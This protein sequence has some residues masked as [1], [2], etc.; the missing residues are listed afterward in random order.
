MIPTDIHALLIEDNAEHALLLG[1]LLATSAN[2]RFR[3][4]VA[5]TLAEGL[6]KIPRDKFDIILL[7]LTLPDCQGLPTF[8]KVS[9]AAG[10][11]PIVVLSGIGD[12]ALAIETVQKGAQDYLVKGHVD[13]HLL[14]RSVQYAVERKRTQLELERA[15][16]ELEKRVKERTIE[17]LAT[18]EHLQREV[19]DRK[20][21]ES[22]AL[23]S[24]RQLSAALT[25]LR[26]MQQDLVRR[27]RFQALAQMA[28]GIAHEFNNIL[29]PIAG[30]AE[31]LLKHPALADVPEAVRNALQKVRN[32]AF[33]GSKAV[34]RVR[35]FARASAGEFGPVS[36]EELVESAIGLTEPRWRDE[37]Q[38]AGVTIVLA[39]EVHDAP[40]LHGDAAQLREVLTHLIFNAVQAIARRGLIKVGAEK[41]GGGVALYVQDDGRG[42]SEA[43][44]KR[45]LDPR[46]ATKTQDGRSAGYAVI[47]SILARH[48]GRLEIESTPRQGTKV[49][50]VLPSTPQAVTAPTPEPIPEPPPPPP[51]PTGV[52]PK[53]VLIVDDEPMIREVISMFFEDHGF[54]VETADD[55]RSAIEKFRSMPYD[56]VMTDRAMPEMNGDQLAREIKELHPG[57]PVILLTGYG[58][59]MNQDGERP[60]GVDAVVAKP[61][62]TVGLRQV[63]VDLKMI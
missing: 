51:R 30:Y 28:N 25:E 23:E 16:T 29:T 37:A 5:G 24:N 49:S 27:E 33:A 18:N 44:R 41:R 10:N 11:L 46:A 3:L 53:R 62:S 56:L 7:D 20:K 54:T 59:Q 55:G 39:Q 9:A 48:H 42:M 8:Q 17:L 2:P 43:D 6:E 12:V 63:L 60:P 38:A 35:D 52:S 21:A 47:H 45:C 4:T 15:N 26:A 13:N 19:E 1:K 57:T 22:Q 58:E 61:F 36:V 40:S 50:V 14:L 32:T 34:T 31:Q